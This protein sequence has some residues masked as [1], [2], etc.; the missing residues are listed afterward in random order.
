SGL[1]DAV[2]KSKILPEEA[3]T[4]ISEFIKKHFPNKGSAILAGNSV[5]VDKRF[6]EKDFPKTSEYFHYRIIDVSTVKELTRRWYPEVF[7]NSP[8]FQGLHRALDDIRGSINEL[9]YYKE[10]VFKQK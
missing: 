1:V 5:H 10:K 3:D 4:I 6:L 8:S 9:K 7:T 2:R